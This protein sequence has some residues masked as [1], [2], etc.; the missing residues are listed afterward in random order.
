MN[1]VLNMVSVAASFTV[2]FMILYLIQNYTIGQIKSFRRIVIFER[3]YLKDLIFSAVA[4]LLIYFFVDF[5]LPYS[6]SR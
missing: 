1:D 6:P 2:V 3:F 4:L 5:V